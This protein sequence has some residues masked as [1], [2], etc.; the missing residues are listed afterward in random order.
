M[1]DAD[2]E[3]LQEQIEELERLFEET[4]AEFEEERQNWEETKAEFREERER[5]EEIREEMVP[6]DAVEVALRQYGVESE[7][8]DRFL[9]LLRDVQERN[10]FDGE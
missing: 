1:T 7:A 2:V 6:I 9:D 3:E 8:R 4:R 10:E 5:W